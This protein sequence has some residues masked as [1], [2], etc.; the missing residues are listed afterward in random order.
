M[1][2]S[3][4]RWALPHSQLS[5]FN[6]ERMN[7]RESLA[8]LIGFYGPLVIPLI[9]YVA[10]RW[11]IYLNQRGF[12]RLCE[13]VGA[14]AK[15]YRD[16]VPVELRDRC[17]KLLWLSISSRNTFEALVYGHTHA[18]KD[19]ED[20]IPFPTITM[21]YRGVVALI[22]ECALPAS[23]ALA[24][25]FR[26]DTVA[27]ASGPSQEYQSGDK[28]F[29]ERVYIS[30]EDPDSLSNYLT[31]ERRGK[32]LEL[33]QGG[34]QQLLYVRKTGQLVLCSDVLFLRQH[35]NPAAAQ[36]LLRDFSVLIPEPSHSSSNLSTVTNV[37]AGVR[38]TEGERGKTYTFRGVLGVAL[39][40]LIYLDGGKWSSTLLAW[41]EFLGVVALVSA[42][43]ILAI[44]AIMF[45][46]VRGTS[47]GHRVVMSM[48]GISML[49]APLA[50]FLGLSVSNNLLDSATAREVSGQFE[51]IVERRRYRSISYA[52]VLRVPTQSGGVTD[53]RI[54]LTKSRADEL[55][56]HQGRDASVWIKPGF[57][58]FEHVT[59]FKVNS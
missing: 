50:T 54:P 15:T 37:S 42:I 43:I 40:V 31:A 1:E 47:N 18:A 22:S 13:A 32:I 10:I 49:T 21:G 14:P 38:E 9:I 23:F 26:G 51:A 33:L 30:C 16:I 12:D 28:R 7:D 19:A 53:V 45:Q 41:R 39:A 55:R 6:G 25:E 8:Y 3:I 36:K 44:G 29:D 27:R 56:A 52:A 59:D 17:V 20:A 57:F 48:I 35:F 34:I 11:R 58:G 46:R 4:R 24:R 5:I 2:L